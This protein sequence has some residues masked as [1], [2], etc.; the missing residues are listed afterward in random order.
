[1][2]LILSTKKVVKQCITILR[3]S[4]E[5][6]YLHS[7]SVWEK[8]ERY[9]F[10]E[11]IVIAWLLHD[12]VEDSSMTFE[13]LQEMWYH[14][15]IL[16]LVDYVTHD[17]SIE[18]RTAKREAMMAR[19]TEYDSPQVRAIKLA[20]YWDNICDFEWCSREFIEKMLIKRGSIFI[21][22]GNKHFAGTAFYND[23]MQDYRTQIQLFHGYFK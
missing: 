15:Q 19:C 23:F 1:M 22:Y 13:I 20:D 10:P 8:L 4:W 2:S 5:E 11:H 14:E 9:W 12:I 17:D 16:T 6:A 3:N 21:Y 18:D 7:R